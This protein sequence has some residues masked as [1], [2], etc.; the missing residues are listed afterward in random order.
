MVEGSGEYS[1]AGAT[2]FD[3]EDGD[4]SEDIQVTG[5]FVNLNL[6]GTYQ[7]KYNV[8]DSRGLSADQKI[9]TVIVTPNQ[10]PV[11]TLIGQATVTVNEGE[12]LKY[13][14][15]GKTYIFDPLNVTTGT[16][17]SEES[18]GVNIFDPKTGVTI[19][20][21]EI[22]RKN[23]DNETAE[24]DWNYLTDGMIHYSQNFLSNVSLKALKLSK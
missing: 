6:A 24:V 20:A 18:T 19:A 11:I 23:S 7:V 3:A 9:R 17:Y 10:V 4:I 1:D 8:V 14:I 2:A 22:I 13:N 21:G 5:D 12:L 16:K 15:G